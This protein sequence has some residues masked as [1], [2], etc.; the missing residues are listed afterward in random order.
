[1]PPPRDDVALWLIDLHPV[2]FARHPSAA[3]LEDNLAL[4]ANFL[5]QHTRPVDRLRFA[6]AWWETFRRRECENPGGARLPYEDF[7]EFARRAGDRCYRGMLRAAEIADRRWERGN[8]KLIIADRAADNGALGPIA[9]RGV[10]ELG[11]DRIEALRDDPERSCASSGFDDALPR[12]EFRAMRFPPPSG[13]SRIFGHRWT[14][15]RRAWEMGHAF[16]RRG[17]GAA[18]PLWFSSHGAGECLLTEEIPAAVSLAAILSAA[19]RDSSPNGRERDAFDVRLREIARTLAD[20]LRLM[21]D[22]RFAHRELTAERV[23]VSAG[24]GPRGLWFAGMESV[25]RGSRFAWLFRRRFRRMLGRFEAD[26]RGRPG[27]T[28][29]LRARFL[30]RFL[31]PDFRN[32]WK[33]TWRDVAREAARFD[34]QHIEDA[35][36]ATCH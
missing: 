21:R 13:S 24:D 15:A 12:C 23:L 9:C 32:G 14:P 27:V 30:R 3:R 26:L 6:R 22:A 2:D 31:G 35:D 17:I 33:R 1:P 19:N 7:R 16:V 34:S 8:R 11:R 20:R 4:L 25:H 10:A 29:M 36:R 28:L 5:W 18:R